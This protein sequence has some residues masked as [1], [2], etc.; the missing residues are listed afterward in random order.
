MILSTY[1]FELG[2]KGNF[3]SNIYHSQMPLVAFRTYS[4]I[5]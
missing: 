5:E 3:T 1:I 4:P 2:I